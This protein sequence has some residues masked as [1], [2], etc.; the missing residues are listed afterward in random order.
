MSRLP[1]LDPEE[2]SVAT[3]L[4]A[5]DRL[6]IAQALGATLA[7]M[8]LPTWAESAEYDDR[9]AAL[10]HLAAGHAA[11]VVARLRERAHTPHRTNPADVR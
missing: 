7:A 3:G 8:Q 5:A 6:D 10:R 1:G 4:T 2:P 11:L 9:T